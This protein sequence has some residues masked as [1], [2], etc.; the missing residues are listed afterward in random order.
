MEMLAFM[1][2][3]MS[4]YWKKR[5]R[6]RQHRSST[7]RL[8]KKKNQIIVIECLLQVNGIVMNN[9]EREPYIIGLNDTVPI[10]QDDDGDDDFVVPLQCEAPHVVNQPSNF[11]SSYQSVVNQPSNTAKY[12]V[13]KDVAIQRRQ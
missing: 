10:A 4:D 7:Q 11:V 2:S 5:D 13:K 12:S 6:T 8:K 1:Q 9:E 3:E